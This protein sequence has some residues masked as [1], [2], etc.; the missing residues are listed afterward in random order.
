LGFW[1]ARLEMTISNNYESKH[2]YYFDTSAIMGLGNKIFDEKIK[3]QCYI[4]YLNFTELLN[5]IENNFDRTQKLLQN[6]VKSGIGITWWS[7]DIIFL[8]RFAPNTHDNLGRDL[9][10]VIELV[11]E[12]QDLTHFFNLHKEHKFEEYDYFYFKDYDQHFNYINPDR[13]SL[14][15]NIKS[16]LNSIGLTLESEVWKLAIDSLRENFSSVVEY[17]IKPYYDTLRRKKVINESLSTFAKRYDNSLNIFMLFSFC[18]DT[19]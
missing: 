16:D 4:S 17:F 2:K 5:K 1:R 9:K 12:A 15:A 10:A 18:I 14:L 8:R 3:N 13:K 7:P 6:I 19:L 11:L